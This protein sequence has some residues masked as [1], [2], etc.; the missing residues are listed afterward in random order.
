MIG[1]LYL[2]WKKLKDDYTSEQI[3][4]CGFGVLLGVTFGNLVGSIFFP[5][6]RFWLTLMG[7]VLALAVGIK[8]FRMRFFE[9]LEAWTIGSLAIL[10]VSNLYDLFSEANY[11]DLVFL[12]VTFFLII[13]FF[14]INKRYKRYVWY[15]SGKVGF[16]SL[17][18]LGLYFIFRVSTD[19]FSGIMALRIVLDALF[20]GLLSFVSFLVLFRRSQDKMV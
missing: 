6:F 13:I 18:V 3:F 5:D 8:R 9:L 17:M 15:R 12:A 1:F 20:S 4:T 10:A 7:S 19:L 14:Y 2:F 11:L 16:S